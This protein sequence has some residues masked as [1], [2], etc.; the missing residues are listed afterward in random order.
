VAY[1][2][3]AMFALTAARDALRGVPGRTRVRQPPAARPARGERP[4]RDGLGIVSDGRTWMAVHAI[5]RNTSDLRHDLGLLALERRAGR[6]WRDL[7]AARPRTETT[8]ETGRA[9]AAAR[10]GSRS[11]RR[12]TT[13]G[14]APA[15]CASPATTGRARS[16]PPRHADLRAHPQGR[17]LHALRRQAR[18]RLPPPGL[19]ARRH[20][21]GRKRASD[22]AGARWRFDRPVA[23]RRLAGYNSAPVERLDAI[24]AV[25]T[26]PG[27]AAS[28]FLTEARSDKGRPGFIPS[29]PSPALPMTTE[30]LPFPPRRAPFP[31]PALLVLAVLLCLAAPAAA[32]AYTIGMS[33]Q[34]VGMWQ[35]PPL[36]QARH[37]AGPPAD[38]LRQRPARDFS[39]YDAWMTAA[40]RRG[41]DVLVTIDRDIGSY[42]RM[43]SLKQ[44][45]KVVRILRKRYPWVE[46]VRR[47][48]RGQPRQAADV[49]QAQAGGAVL[50][51]SSARSARL[52][53]PRRRLLDSKNMLS[54]VRGLQAVRE[55]PEALG[56]AHSYQDSNHFRPLSRPTP[57]ALLRAVK[58][59]ALAHG[60]GRHR[61][62]RDPL[63]RRQ[64]GERQRHA[65]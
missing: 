13:C 1:N 27:R 9:D 48:E 53:D 33:D 24:E 36:R 64:G 3:L 60:G 21:R 16:G 30:R 4:R 55:A 6:R 28:G 19:H 40:H 32:K 50:Q 2:G 61:P 39:R 22:A 47:V 59:R 46:H 20:G 26:V 18:R 25:V 51:T 65:R 23:V 45:R 56:P 41:A 37:Q 43:P 14:S 12:A 31:A 44:Y 62:L 38:G 5:R 42:T 10:R 11:R 35:D 63:P 54:W 57:R 8:A 49:P 7:L 34:K 52:H 17:P 58:G 29:T 15:A